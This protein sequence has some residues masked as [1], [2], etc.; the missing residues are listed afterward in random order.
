VQDAVPEPGRPD[1]DGPV[2]VTIALPAPPAGLSVALVGLFRTPTYV[3]VCALGMLVAFA[4]GAFAA[5]LPLYLHRVKRFD[6]SE[7]SLWYGSLT[8]SAGL[9]GVVAGGW[10]G[11]TLAR[12]TPAGHLL[13]IAG[14][15]VLSAP[16]GLLFL[17][18]DNP[19]V[20]LPA[21]FVAIFFLVLYVGS[22]NAVIHNVVHPSLRATAVAIF[23]FLIHL[24]GDAMSPL[25]VGLIS[26][27]RRSLQ[28][29][30]LFLPVIIFF[31]GV[32]ALAA[33]TVIAA[34]MRRV[35]RRLA[36]VSS[37]SAPYE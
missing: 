18:H 29:A 15:F 21:L 13:T 35:E 5:W 27:R 37:R 4:T 24:G 23:V 1:A 32:I 25:I 28:A 3:M 30:M 20:F 16:F 11:D 22:S 36:M 6:V 8:A 9:L 19:R 10:I 34:D 31:A 17:Q 12:R 33:A 14:G 7:A 26:D 2:A